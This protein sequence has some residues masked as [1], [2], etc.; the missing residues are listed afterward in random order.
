MQPSVEQQR[1]A[2]QRALD[3]QGFLIIYESPGMRREA[4]QVILAAD[5]PLQSCLNNP[6]AS[7]LVIGEATQEEALH[8]ML[9][10]FSWAMH[11]PTFRVLKVVCE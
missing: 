9:T 6:G 8:Q 7:Y 4:G 3:E 11:E 10:Y 2:C 1:E 5:T